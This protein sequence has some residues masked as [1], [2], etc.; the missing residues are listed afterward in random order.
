MISVWFEK[1]V[2]LHQ[3]KDMF[4]GDKLDFQEK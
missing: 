1:L 3:I 2:D 4:W